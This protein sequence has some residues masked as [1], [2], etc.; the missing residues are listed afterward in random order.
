[1]LELEHELAKVRSHMASNAAR[2]DEYYG[3]A[4][5]EDYSA[6]TQK[7]QVLKEAVSMTVNYVCNYV[8]KTG[9]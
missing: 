7:I 5:D 3:E 4:L 6:L 2:M 8:T 1:M 9:L